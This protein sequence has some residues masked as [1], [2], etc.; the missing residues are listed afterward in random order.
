MAKNDYHLAVI[1]AGAGGLIAS[2]FAARLGA[3]VAL[4]ERDRI[5]GDCTWTG[6]VPSKSLIRAAKAAHEI[7]A[8]ERFGITPGSLTVRM[9]DVRAYIRGKVQ[10]IYEPTTPDAL[11][12]EG[13]DVIV[14]PAAFV[15][16]HTI[17]VRDRVVRADHY[18]IATG[19]SPVVPAIAGLGDVP[20]FT[21][22]N[23]FDND[24]LP[25]S[26]VVIGGGPL[27]MEIAQAYQRLGARATIVA[28]RLLARDEPEAADI[29]RRVFEREGVRLV[30][31]RAT[32]VRRDAKAIV[33]GS[34]REEARGECLL[35][36]VGR[37]PN[38]HGLELERAGVR[39]S[40]CGVPVDDRLRTNAR[41]IYAAGDVIGGEQFS[42]IA[43]WQ[44]FE[45]ARNA[46]L[47]GSAS[48]RPNPIAWVTFTDP[49]VAQVGLTERQARERLGDRVRAVTWENR[50]VDRAVCDDEEDGFIKIVTEAGGAIVGATI[51]AHRAGD[52]S[53]EM[54]VA[55]AQRLTIRDIAA[56]V[57]A[58]PTY[59][60][61]VEQMASELA[62][63]N[64]LSSVQGRIVTRLM[65]FAPSTR[66]AHEGT[67]AEARR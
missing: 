42:H 10:R 14:G 30:F 25:E 39:Y 11:S 16:A 13:I 40:E 26:L 38:V 67:H 51:V 37:R 58:Y 53:A 2:R 21:Y 31:G 36:A 9:S 50:R 7:R 43:G 4:V 66:S 5:G 3:R 12:Q 15:D 63:S 62:T 45:A 57:H 47:P 34:E 29:M 60:T 33:V 64:W 41:H 22:L 49:E 61:A 55:I 59:A 44:A 48:G 65:G 1:G 18:L 6:C 35:V 56:A 52:V 24:R 46:L 32:S 17:R 19:A 8:A 28:P 54:S 23:I 27:G 20:Y